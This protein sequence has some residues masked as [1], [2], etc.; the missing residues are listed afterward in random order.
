MSRFMTDAGNAVRQLTLKLE[1]YGF[2]YAH[3]RAAGLTPWDASVVAAEQGA[4]K[5]LPQ[6]VLQVVRRTVDELIEA[7]EAAS[8]TAQ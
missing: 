5:G 6:Q 8:S 7:R 3:S 1:N 4:E 2:L